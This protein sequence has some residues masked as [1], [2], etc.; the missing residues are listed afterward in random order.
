[1][2]SCINSRK[3]D[4]IKDRVG[5]LCRW[6]WPK[7]PKTNSAMESPSNEASA[8]SRF[9]FPVGFTWALHVVIVVRVR[10]WIQTQATQF[11]L[12]T[13]GDSEVVGWVSGHVRW[14]L[15]RCRGG[16]GLGGRGKRGRRGWG[17]SAVPT[18]GHLHRWLLGLVCWGTKTWTWG[19]PGAWGISPLKGGQA[20]TYNRHDGHHGV[21]SCHDLILYWRGLVVDGGCRVPGA[22]R[23]RAYCG[24]YPR[25]WRSAGTGEDWDAATGSNR[26]TA[27]G[28]GGNHVGWAHG[29]LWCAGEVTWRTHVAWSHRC[30]GRCTEARHNTSRGQRGLHAACGGWESATWDRC[31]VNVRW[32]HRTLLSCGLVMN[33]L[34]TSY[35]G[36][37]TPDF[38]S[39]LNFR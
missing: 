8:T 18:A 29:P 2:A 24:V 25:A 15:Y 27:A 11:P 4:S 3:C 6:A 39:P 26:S 19:G 13:G 1:M 34:H 30:D 38:Q 28:V 12:Y 17:V 22:A 16:H 20:V 9:H 36:G 21:K 23:A 14:G 35:K 33:V 7:Y 31:E 10:C 5:S 37:G 32:R